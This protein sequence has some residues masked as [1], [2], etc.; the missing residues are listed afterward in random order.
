[1]ALQ[2]TMATAGRPKSVDMQK[3]EFNMALVLVCIV[4]MF[5]FCQSIKIIPDFYEA[6]ACDYSKQ[7]RSLVIYVYKSKTEYVRKQS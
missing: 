2:K 7:V 1:M 6:L 3:K 4:V 5:I